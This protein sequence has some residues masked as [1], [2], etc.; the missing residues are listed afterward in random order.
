MQAKWAGVAGLLLAVSSCRIL[1]L[2]DPAVKFGTTFVSYG[3][4]YTGDDPPVW[5]GVRVTFAIKNDGGAAITLF[6]TTLEQETGG[7]WKYASSNPRGGVVGGLIIQP[8]QSKEATELFRA[9]PGATNWPGATITGR[10]RLQ[11]WVSDRYGN[12]VKGPMGYT[13]PFAIVEEQGDSR[14]FSVITGVK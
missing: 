3:M 6:D 13:A 14:T 11:A 2:A 9:S 10:Y 1:G 4:V 5:A 12:V 7:V 8:G